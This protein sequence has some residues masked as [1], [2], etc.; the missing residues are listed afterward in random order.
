MTPDEVEKAKPLSIPETVFA[1][2]NAMIVDNWNGTEAHFT[3]DAV[4]N[5][6]LT[7]SAMADT[8]PITKGKLFDNHWM[9]IEPTY[10]QAGWI[11]E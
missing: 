7:L 2:L 4:A 6:I 8:R 1:G 3:Q 5:R 11:V 9:D 10:R